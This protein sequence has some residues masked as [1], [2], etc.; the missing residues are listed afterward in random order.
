MTREGYQAYMNYLALQ[1]HFSS[2]YDFFKYNGKT[3]GSA[4]SYQKRNDMWSFEKL[5]KIIPEEKQVDFFVANFLQDQNAWIKNMSKKHLDAYDATYKNITSIFKDDLMTIKQEGPSNVLSVSGDI[6]RIYKM[7]LQN[8]I[9]IE[10]VV[11]LDK[12]FPFVD[13]HV[14]QVQVP[15]V[16]PDLV[17]KIKNY[18]PFAIN[19]IGNRFDLLI[20]VAR[21]VL[22]N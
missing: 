15:F 10:T 11:I 9:K 14:E 2:D 5:A 7:L 13:K 4:E 22:L 1:R 8:E 12:I 19:K 16:F 18:E 21:N 17:K 6:P 3:R 20:D